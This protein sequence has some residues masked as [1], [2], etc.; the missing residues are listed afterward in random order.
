MSY[1][2]LAVDLAKNKYNYIAI[3]ASYTLGDA[4][5]HLG[6]YREA[7]AILVDNLRQ[8]VAANLKDNTVKGFNTLT[9]VYKATG[10]YKKAVET[11]ESMSVL[12]GS[13]S[14]FASAAKIG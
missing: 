13:P 9:Q 14:S 7:E 10:Q 8:A 5:Y 12:T 11:I 6:K 2:Q 4:L 3:N 1:L